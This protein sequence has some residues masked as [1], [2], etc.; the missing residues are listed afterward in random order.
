MTVFQS[1]QEDPNK[2]LLMSSCVQRIILQLLEN[3]FEMAVQKPQP[4]SY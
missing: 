4:Q 3:A 1:L 2:H